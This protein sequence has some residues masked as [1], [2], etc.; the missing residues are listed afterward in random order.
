MPDKHNCACLCY[1]CGRPNDLFRHVH[2][3]HM[4]EHGEMLNKDGEPTVVLCIP[5]IARLQNALNLPIVAYVQGGS[6]FDR[7]GRDQAQRANRRGQGMQVPQW[8]IDVLRE[9]DQQDGNDG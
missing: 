3:P 9:I 7:Y 1:M 6:V 5:C 2:L 4:D 8:A